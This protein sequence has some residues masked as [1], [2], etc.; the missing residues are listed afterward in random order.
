MS[1]AK[2]IEEIK[3]FMFNNY[4][5]EYDVLDSHFINGK[6]KFEIKHKSCNT[7]FY[8]NLRLN[9]HRH[10]KSNL[11]PIYLQISK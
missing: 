1:R 6:T 10:H 2:N 11:M 3:E 8:H 7:I 4:N 9:L 5:N